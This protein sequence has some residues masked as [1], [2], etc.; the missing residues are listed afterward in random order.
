MDKSLPLRMVLLSHYPR[1]VITPI[2]IIM[3]II[4]TPMITMIIIV[5]APA[6]CGV[7]AESV[8]KA[9]AASHREVIEVLVVDLDDVDDHDYDDGRDNHSGDDYDG[10]YKDNHFTETIRFTKLELPVFCSIWSYL[11]NQFQID[12]KLIL[13]MVWPNIDPWVL[14]FKTIIYH[15]V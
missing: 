12:I 11:R 4:I 1:F 10:H 13:N 15:S 6:H 2:I 3:L 14:A 7:C 5:K 9:K 8:D